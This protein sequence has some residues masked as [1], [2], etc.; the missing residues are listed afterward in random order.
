MTSLIG[1]I[2]A[3]IAL[4]RPAF[5]ALAVVLGGV[6]T[7]DWMVR[8][9]RISPFGAVARALHR[10]VDPLLMP[11]ERR[12]VRAGGLP[13]HAPFWAL[14]AVVL[15]GILVIAG[16]GFLRDQLA[17]VAG[18]LGAG[19]RGV[20]RLT[21]SWAITLLQIAI[22]VRVVM[23]WIHLRPGAWYVRWSYRL[24]E[25]ILRPIRNLVPLI[26]MIDISPIIAWFALGIVEALLLAAW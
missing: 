19:P 7:V 18:S 9:R 11:I 2:D 3:L 4:A 5:L 13:A 17:F 1:G 12:V 14:M 23:S 25:P 24:S 8:T 6:A 21:V 26:G 22:V 16:L 15:T 20:Y 10:H